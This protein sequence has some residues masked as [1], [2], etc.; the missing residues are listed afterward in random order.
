MLRTVPDGF[1]SENQLILKLTSLPFHFP[2]GDVPT[3]VIIGI[4]VGS[5][6]LL[7]AGLLIVMVTVNTYSKRKK[8]SCYDTGMPTPPAACTIGIRCMY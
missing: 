1:L 2:T 8:G 6:V 4:S 5:A 7:M 3:N